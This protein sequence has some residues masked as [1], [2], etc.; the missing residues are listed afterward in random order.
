MGGQISPRNALI[1]PSTLRLIRDNG[2]VLYNRVNA[3]GYEVCEDD[4]QAASGIAEDIQDGLLD[5]QVGDEQH[6]RNCWESK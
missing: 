4:I 1:L 5:Y 2:N 3:P 6:F